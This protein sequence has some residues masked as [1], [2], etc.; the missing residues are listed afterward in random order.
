MR[1]IG[2]AIVE[3]KAGFSHTGITVFYFKFDSMCLECTFLCGNVEHHLTHI[4][5]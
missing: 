2:W 1:L 3:R 5:D 4:W